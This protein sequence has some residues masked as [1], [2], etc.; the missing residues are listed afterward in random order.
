MQ[1]SE[2]PEKQQPR[3]VGRPPKYTTEELRERLVNAGI[4]AVVQEGMSHGLEAARLEAAIHRAKVPRR[5]AYRLWENDELESPQDA[6][7]R[8]VLISLLETIPLSSG[9]GM[10]RDAAAKAL[11]EHAETLESGD[12]AQLDRAMSDAI[13]Q[14]SAA[15]FAN[16]GDSA[17]WRVYQTAIKAATTQPHADPEVFEAARLGEQ[18]LIEAYG[19][20]YDEL[21]ALFRLR[22][23]PGLTMHEFVLSSYALSEGLANRMTSDMFRLDGIELEVDGD[24]ESWTLLGLAF[25]ALVRSFFEP[26]EDV[27]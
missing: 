13:R 14:A 26:E 8:G 10:T 7:R 24:T 16:I 20:F 27:S 2:R 3:P 25:L 17:L 22:I 12:R 19:E 18:R 5:A 23:K 9:L 21:A 1:D 6:F 11:E 15:N 4:E